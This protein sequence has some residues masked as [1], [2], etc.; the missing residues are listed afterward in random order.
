M[1]NPQL[2]NVSDIKKSFYIEKMSNLSEHYK[3]FVQFL[4]QL[5]KLV[6]T[7]N[8]CNKE[9]ALLKHLKLEAKKIIIDE[10]AIFLDTP[11]H[12]WEFSLTGK[13][14]EKLKDFFCDFYG[15][16][17]EETFLEHHE[18]NKLLYAA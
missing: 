4:Y 14:S 12:Q 3:T 9:C 7:Y 5:D 2:P 10:V 17:N 16:C 15:E 11:S 18:K 6:D 8:I 1:L 13:S